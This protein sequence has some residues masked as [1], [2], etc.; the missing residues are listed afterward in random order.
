MKKR[1]LTGILGLLIQST[2]FAATQEDDGAWLM[3]LRGVG[4]IPA[5]KSTITPIG[6]TV[7]VTNTLVPEFDVSYFFTDNIAAELILATTKHKMRAVNTAVGEVDVGSVWLL[8]PTLT[9]QYHFTQLDY[10]KPYAGIGLNYT[11]FYA[12]KAGALSDVSYDNKASLALQ[13]GIDIPVYC[14][15]IYVN[16]DVKK[17]FLKTTAAFNQES[18]LADVKLNPWLVGAGLGFR[19]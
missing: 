8:P 2:L 16:L 11:F 3:R 4:V 13:L 6:G 17:L 9:L 19:F 18:I 15:S 5:E 10:C 12:A 7:Q 1:I 14:N